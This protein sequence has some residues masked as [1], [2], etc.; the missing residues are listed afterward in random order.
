M[1]GFG[2]SPVPVFVCGGIGATPDDHTRACA[3]AAAGVP[4]V[5]HPQAQALI[6][7]RFGPAAYPY[8]ILMAELP[9]GAGL[10]PNPYNGIPGFVL[11]GHWFLPGFPEMA[12]PMAEW[13]LDRH[14]PAA[15]PLEEGAVEVL[16][17]PESELIPLM[18]AIGARFPGLKA[19]SLPRLGADAHIL[20]G[21]RGRQGLQEGMAALRLGLAAGSIGFRE[22]T[23]RLPAQTQGQA[24]GPG[25]ATE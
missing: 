19:F 15:A 14:F 21:L 4:L 17:V 16:G 24:A 1:A 10:V 23:D 3:P 6:E 7:G 22:R 8:R 5:R 11:A 20:L 9:A 12:W 18:D 25:T 13:V 2:G